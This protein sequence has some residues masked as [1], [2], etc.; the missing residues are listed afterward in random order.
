MYNIFKVILIAAA[1]SFFISSIA[2]KSALTSSANFECEK[3]SEIHIASEI[4]I[5]E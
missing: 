1:L 5:L 4:K 2:S 3:E